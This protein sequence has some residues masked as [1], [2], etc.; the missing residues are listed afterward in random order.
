MGEFESL[1]DAL[2]AVPE[3]GGW[4]LEDWHEAGVRIIDSKVE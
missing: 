4:Q 2:A 1:E 3:E